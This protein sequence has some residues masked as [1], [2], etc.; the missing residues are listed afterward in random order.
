MLSLLDEVT[1]RHTNDDESIWFAEPVGYDWRN[2][3]LRFATQPR[4]WYM[5]CM[6]QLHQLVKVECKRANEQHIVLSN[7]LSIKHCATNARVLIKCVPS[8][9]QYQMKKILPLSKYGQL[10]GSINSSCKQHTRKYT[11]IHVACTAEIDITIKWCCGESHHGKTQPSIE[12]HTHSRFDAATC[13]IWFSDF[14]SSQWNTWTLN[15][16]R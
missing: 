11:Q 6:H 13:R 3:S 15:A 1:V 10:Y 4:L 9:Q 12:Q 5:Q 8:M 7:H 16:N 2:T 14:H